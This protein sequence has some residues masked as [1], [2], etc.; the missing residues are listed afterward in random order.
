MSTRSYGQ[1]CAIAKSLD[2]LGGRWSLLVIRE[3]L[4]GPRRFV[5]LSEALPAMGPNLLSARLKELSDAG[6]ITKREIRSPARCLAY[7]LTEMGQGLEEVLLALSRWGRQL[8]SGIRP[9]EQ[10]SAR[11]LL[12]GMRGR[13]GASSTEG[14]TEEYE[15][16]V[17]KETLYARLDDGEL[18]A[19]DGPA[20][21][22]TATLSASRRDFLAVALGRL[23]VGHAIADG[24]L[25]LSGDRKALKRCLGFFLENTA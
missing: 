10:F 17:G 11:W 8:L 24:R 9:D 3:L 14:V 1:F 4:Y 5:D 25:T 15:F 21:N 22:P 6:V 20:E 18:S 19:G 16:R 13:F 12:L 2:I 23:A 7:E